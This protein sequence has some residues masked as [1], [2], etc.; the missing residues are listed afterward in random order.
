MEL[1]GKPKGWSKKSAMKEPLHLPC[2]KVKLGLGVLIEAVTLTAELPIIIHKLN[3]ITLGIVH[4][5][6]FAPSPMK[7]IDLV[8]GINVF[9]TG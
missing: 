1:K 3:R 6:L 9:L 7:I 4:I 2:V 8:N 5:L